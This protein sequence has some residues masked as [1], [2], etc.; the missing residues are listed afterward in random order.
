M[1][2]SRQLEKFDGRNLTRVGFLLPW[3]SF[4]AALFGGGFYDWDREEVILNTPQNLRALRYMVAERQRL[5]YDNVVRFR[6]GIDEN[7]HAGGWPFIGEHY[8]IIA[9]GQWRVEQIA[10]YAPNLDYRTA[11]IPPPE[12]GPM[13]AGNASGNFM[14][15]PR[16]AANPEGA[17]EFLKFWSGIE[18]P[19]R[20][21]RFYVKAGWL[22]LTPAI[23]EAPAYQAYL[24]QYPEFQTFVDLL[25]SEHLQTTAP[26]AYNIYLFD[27]VGQAGDLAMRRL[28]TPEEALLRLEREIR[29]EQDRRR[30]LGYGR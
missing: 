12:G 24:E 11:P 1:E 29:D 3:F 15:I 2:V 6:A 7:D 28:I 18:N 21:A 8:S 26:V 10:R 17:W 22:P 23:A 9:D 20:A 5:G 27:R 30:M 19:E 14:I 25:D 13:H 4:T 16:G